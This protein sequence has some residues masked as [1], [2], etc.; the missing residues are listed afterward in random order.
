MLL[1][2]DLDDVLADSITALINFHNRVF[3]TRLTI[4]DH[5]G[6]DLDLIWGCSRA[7]ATRRLE[8]FYQSDEYRAIEPLDGAVAAIQTLTEHQ[9]LVVLTAREP[10]PNLHAETIAWVDQ[11]FAGCFTDIHFSFTTA[12]H[13]PKGKLAKAL[14]VTHAF[15]DG[16]R[17]AMNYHENGIRT[18][19]FRRPWNA[20]IPAN[21]IAI[22]ETWPEAIREFQQSKKGA[23]H[24]PPTPRN[25]HR[26]TA[27]RDLCDGP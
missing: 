16:P 23:S 18:I 10:F 13:Q 4:Q 14:G 21:G 7:E 20:H 25:R 12:M 3:G 9:R 1:A 5:N 8:L 17:H 26:V 27:P 6:W 19:L 15:E 11:H 24:G 2:I 22:V